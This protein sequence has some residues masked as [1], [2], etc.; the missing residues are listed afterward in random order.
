MCT[1]C[2]IRV[3]FISRYIIQFYKMRLKYFHLMIRIF[4]QIHFSLRQF[5][6][7]QRIVFVKRR[8]T[9]Y[10]SIRQ[11]KIDPKSSPKMAHC[12]PH[13]CFSIDLNTRTLSAN[14]I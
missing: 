3:P 9:S 13:A 8:N 4:Y 6:V 1:V 10:Q 7:E 11:L 2:L 14:N 12:C 5:S